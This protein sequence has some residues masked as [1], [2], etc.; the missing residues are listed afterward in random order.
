MA[1]RVYVTVIGSSRASEWEMEAAEEV[2]RLVAERGGVLVTGGRGGVMLAAARGAK[3]AGGLTVGVLPG[4]SRAEA[5][6]YIDVALPTGL[7]H[8]RNAVNVLAGDVVVAVGG[9]AGTLSEIGLALAYGRP[10]VALEGPG[11]AGM[12][13][14]KEV[15]GVRVYAAAT[16]REAVELAF[17]LATGGAIP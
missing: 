1:G 13:A 4:T 2:G 6:P 8:A 11:V 9:G 5:N 12:L 3:S 17:R 7:G 16:P 14:G 10:V 15:G